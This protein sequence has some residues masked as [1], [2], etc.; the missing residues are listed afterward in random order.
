ME[1]AV[2]VNVRK[3]QK[4]IA[5]RQSPSLQASLLVAFRIIRIQG[6]LFDMKLFIILVTRSLYCINICVMDANYL[7]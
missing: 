1:R 6:L 7:I 2:I 3:Y 5:G 4:M